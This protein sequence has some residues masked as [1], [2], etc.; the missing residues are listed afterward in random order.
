VRE[1]GNYAEEDWSALLLVLCRFS[2]FS[3]T[4]GCGI[5]ESVG[6]L[7]FSLGLACAADSSKTQ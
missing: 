6:G 1:V 4:K 7:S 3:S 5:S 2:A